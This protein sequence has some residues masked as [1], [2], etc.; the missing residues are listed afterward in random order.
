MRNISY[1][2]EL[3]KRLSKNITLKKIKSVFKSFSKSTLWCLTDERGVESPYFQES[4][5]A[6]RCTVYTLLSDKERCGCVR[7][8]IGTLKKSQK[9]KKIEKFNCKN[10]THGIVLPISQGEKIYGYLIICQLDKEVPRDLVNLLEISLEAVL[11]ET[12]KELELSKL[13]ETIR[14][15]AVALSTVHTIYRLISSTLNLE[16]LLPRISRLFSQVLRANSCFITLLGE[17]DSKPTRVATDT[18]K[19]SP[20]KKDIKRALGIERKVIRTSKGILNRNCV[21]MPLIDEDT[22]GVISVF[23]KIEKGF[24]H[25]DQ[26]ILS[27][28]T[29]QSVIAIKNAKLYK[30]QENITL[31][32]IKSLATVLEARAP[33]TYKNKAIFAKIVYAMGLELHLRE[34]ELKALHYAALL[35][36][37]SQAVLPDDIL[38]KHTN[39][40]DKE[41]KIIRQVPLKSAKILEPLKLL[42]PA[43]PIILFHHENFDGTGYPNGLKGDEIPIGAR[44]MSVAGAFSAMI[45]KRP[46]RKEMKVDRAIEE[47]KNASGTKFDPKTVEVFL[48]IIKREDIS[49]SLRKK[50]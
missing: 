39:L 36:D 38:R 49:S 19:K 32:S 28:L 41:L 6:S 18:R 33:K 22:I 47:I 3:F 23:D 26:E 24:D 44:I 45:T 31:A 29:E 21:S 15:R 4:K 34:E 8:L 11:K 10:D 1:E 43:M 12:Q 17:S 37:A 50:R 13:Y 48:K 16:E 9:S 5:I 46:Y 25:F 42:K 35:H 40:T 20:S 27:R 2:S 14:P 30:E 7:D